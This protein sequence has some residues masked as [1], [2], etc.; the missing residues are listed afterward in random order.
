MLIPSHT[1]DMK[2]YTM[3]FLPLPPPPPCFNAF[4]SFP[5][6]YD[7]LKKISNVISRADRIQLE[8]LT[9]YGYKFLLFDGMY[10]IGLI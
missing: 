8:Q 4:S 9:G 6:G 7:V 3:L 10:S 5:Q 2:N 1:G